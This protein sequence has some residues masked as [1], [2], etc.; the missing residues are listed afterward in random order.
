V[1]GDADA[2]RDALAALDEAFE[3]GDL[4]TVPVTDLVSKTYPRERLPRNFSMS[5]SIVLVDLRG[6]FSW[7]SFPLN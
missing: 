7:P 6:V 5:H 4:Q 2:I 3:H 1:D